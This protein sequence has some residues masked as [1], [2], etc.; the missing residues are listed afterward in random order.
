MSDPSD[1]STRLKALE[2]DFVAPKAARTNSPL[3]IFGILGAAAIVGAGVYFALS[4]PE[5]TPRMA[6]QSARDFQIG[7]SA[8]GDMDMVRRDP[9]PVAPPP[10]ATAPEPAPERPSEM[11]A[12]LEQLSAMQAELAALRDTPAPADDGRASELSDLQ[13]QIRDMQAAADQAGREAQEAARR[14]DRELSERNREI[15]RLES[16]LQMARLS[17][18]PAQIA[19]DTRD[20]ERE[21]LERRRAAAEEARLARLN[22]PMLAIG[23][24]EGGSGGAESAQDASRL[25][26]NEEFVRNVG[27]PAPVERANVIVNPANT[28][29]QGS[30]IQASLETA[31][32]SSLPGPIRA[33]VTQ[34]VHSYDGTR[35]LIPRGSRLTGRYSANVSIGQYRAMIAW[36]R[37]ILPDNQTVTIS[38]YGGDAIGRS[39]VSGRVN[40]RFGERF[41]AA[42]LIS[43]LSSGPAL[44]AREIE[45]DMARDGATRVSGDLRDATGSVVSEYLSL[46][47]II[48]INQGARV[49]VM[50]DRDLEIF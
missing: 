9:P 4:G 26:D 22:S 17:Q 49:T 20:L 43:L 6:T 46:P 38:A 19:G 5:T 41:G 13:R 21:E 12:L 8:F 14:L 25:D 27:R 24:R 40:R 45:S 10:T 30:V 2:D 32:D 18:P 36:E 39:G 31:I 23:G 11:T 28:V 33:V 35:I 50:V 37:I 42:A 1:L 48:T 34:D 47:P 29:T 7:G 15:T 44:A 16:E 3:L